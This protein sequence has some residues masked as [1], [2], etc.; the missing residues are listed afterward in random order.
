MYNKIIFGTVL[1]MTGLIS[2][3]YAMPPKPLI[4]PNVTSIRSV[5]LSYASP[6]MNG[7][8]F[9]YQ[10][11]LYNTKDMWAFVFA[12]ISA[13]SK[14]E[15]LSIGNKWL[16]TLSGAPQPMPLAAQNIWYC[17]YQTNEGNYGMAFTPIDFA[18]KLDQFI[19]GVT[20]GTSA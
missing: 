7:G 5:G 6:I 10:L 3:N 19:M 13:A 15:A 4:C 9:A 12:D 17:L 8:Y 1:G 2:L 18:M 11:N 20:H 14:Q 16:D